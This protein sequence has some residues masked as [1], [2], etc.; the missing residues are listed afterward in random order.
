MESARSSEIARS[1]TV[2]GVDLATKSSLS[3]ATSLKLRGIYYLFLLAELSI[4]LFLLLVVKYIDIPLQHLSPTVLARMRRP[5]AAGDGCSRRRV[6]SVRLM[7][8]PTRALITRV[9]DGSVDV[10]GCTYFRECTSLRPLARPA[11]Q[12]QR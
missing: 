12:A 4:L 10:Q 2:Q 1:W 3:A 5:G 7:W 8:L 11:R 6:T 9:L